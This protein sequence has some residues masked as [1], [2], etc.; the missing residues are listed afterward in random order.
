MTKKNHELDKAKQEVSIICSLAIRFNEAKPHCNRRI[1]L[2]SKIL[3]SRFLRQIIFNGNAYRHISQILPLHTRAFCFPVGDCHK[4][5]I[6][7][8]EKAEKLIWNETAMIP[9]GKIHLIA[10]TIPGS[11]FMLD[12]ELRTL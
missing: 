2:L 12:F 10:K 4:E 5:N 6:F 3:H 1:N 8:L 9:P 11:P 7:L